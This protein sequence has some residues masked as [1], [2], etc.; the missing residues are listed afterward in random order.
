MT[1]PATL[2]LASAPKVASCCK[3][4]TGKVNQL[5]A[6]G[7]PMP[8]DFQEL[9]Q[10]FGRCIKACLCRLC[11]YSLTS[12]ANPTGVQSGGFNDLPTNAALCN[13]CLHPCK[14]WRKSCS[15][16]QVFYKWQVVIDSPANHRAVLSQHCCGCV[17]HED[18]AAAIVAP[19][20]A[21]RHAFAHA[22]NVCML[23]LWTS[24]SSAA[25]FVAVVSP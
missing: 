17:G 15:C 11:V 7:K 1:F 4:M 20:Y 13:D 16:I 9:E 21:R 23:A 8:K 3:S 10:E 14:R 12:C 19:T 18:M 22:M 25:A 2:C 6:E 5:K 24:S